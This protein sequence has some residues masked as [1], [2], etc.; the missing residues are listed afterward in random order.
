MNAPRD[1]A[2]QKLIGRN[3][4]EV[5][6]TGV[7]LS[8]A[9]L[10]EA[11]FAIAR[12]QDANLVHANLK[13]IN[14]GETQP[15]KLA[16]ISA[17]GRFIASIETDGK[18]RLWNAATGYELFFSSELPQNVA[19]VVF[20]PDSKLLASNGIN[21][22]IYLWDVETRSLLKTL[23]GH[24]TPIKSLAFSPDG[25][26]LASGGGYNNEIVIVWDVA[27]GNKQYT[28]IGHSKTV[29]YLA[30]SP[31]GQILASCQ[32]SYNQSS[33][34]LWDIAT[35][36]LLRKLEQFSH[37]IE[38][39]DFDVN[40]QSLLVLT[41]N[42]LKKIDLTGQ[43]L[44]FLP[45]HTDYV[46]SVAI[47]ADGKSLVSGSL[48]KT[49]RLWDLGTGEEIKVLTG[50]TS[51]VNSVAIS[52]DGQ[53]LVSGSLDKTIRLWDL[54]TGKEIKVFT[55][56]T[57]SV[58][59]VA[60]SADGQS[61][62]SGS[63]DKTI[64]LWDIGT[65]KEINVFTGH[66][67]LVYSV[68][69]SADGQS[70][71]SG[72]LDKTIRL[73]DIVTGKEI[74]VFTGH[75]DY[76]RSVAVSPDGQS[77][78][79]GSDD[80]TIRL[81]DIATGK[82][83]NVLTG[84]TDY[85][86]SVAI[87][88]D[89]QFLVSGS[90]DKT[91]RLWDIA[92]GK[93]IKVIEGR[94]NPNCFR[95]LPKEENIIIGSRN[96]E[97]EIWD[98]REI[99]KIQTDKLHKKFIN[100]LDYSA[101]TQTLISAGLDK[102]IGL[103]NLQT[104]NRR[105]IRQE[106]H[107]LRAN[108]FGV[109]G[110]R[111]SQKELLLRKGA[112]EIDPTELPKTQNREELRYW[113][114]TRRIQTLSSQIIKEQKRKN[115]TTI[116]IIAPGTFLPPPQSLRKEEL[117][118]YREL[119]WFRRFFSY[120]D[121]SYD[122]KNP[123]LKRIQR[124]FD[125]LYMRIIDDSRFWSEVEEFSP[126][127]LSEKQLWQT[128]KN[129]PDFNVISSLRE[130]YAAL[131]EL[132]NRR[133]FDIVIDFD[134]FSQLN[135]NM[136]SSNVIEESFLNTEDF[137]ESIYR[138]SKRLRY[139]EK[140][141][142][143]F[144]K[145][146]SSQKSPL[147]SKDRK[148]SD[149]RY[150]LED[151]F[152]RLRFDVENPNFILT[153]FFVEGFF[154]FDR[155]FRRNRG[156]DNNFYWVMDESIREQEDISATYL[157]YPVGNFSDFFQDLYTE[158]TISER[159]ESSKFANLTIGQLSYLS[160]NNDEQKRS[161]VAKEVISRMARGEK[162]NRN[163]QS[164][165]TK[166]I[167]SLKKDVS[168]SVRLNFLK[169]ILNNFELLPGNITDVIPDFA[170]DE[171]DSIRA[172]LA[173]WIITKYNKFGKTY[174]SILSDL[175][176]DESYFVRQRILDA[177]KTNLE[178]L[179]SDIRQ[180]ASQLIG[181]QVSVQIISGSGMLIDQESELI[182]EVTN[183]TDTNLEIADLEIL[184][185]A[186]YTVLSRN[187]LSLADLKPE[188]S[189]QATFK[190]KINDPKEITV[191]YKFNGELK[192][193]A[194]SIYAVKGNPYVYGSIVKEEVAFYGRKQELQEIVQGVIQTPIINTFLIGERRLGK[195]SLLY[196]LKKRLETP[197]IPVNV[198]IYKNSTTE[199]ILNNI[200]DEV[201][202]SLIKNK[203]I[204]D[205]L[206][207]RNFLK[208]NNFV[209]SFQEI[210]ERA[211]LKLPNIKIV[212]LLDEADYLLS[213]KSENTGLSSKINLLLEK[214]KGQQSVIEEMKNVLSSELNEIDETVQNILRSALQQLGDNLVAVVAGTSILSSYGAKYNSPFL[215]I[216]RRITL[217][218]LTEEET[219]ALITQPASCLGYTYSEEAINHIIN[220]SGGQPY[221]CQA[222]CYEAFEFATTNQRLS[223]EMNDIKKAEE[224][225]IEDLFDSYFSGFWDRADK[226]QRSFLKNLAEGKSTESIKIERSQI[227]ELINWNLI[228]REQ[229]SYVFCSELNKQWVLMA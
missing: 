111:E 9:D 175:A 15:F 199:E 219:R 181:S 20:S 25:K 45:G 41:N 228:R 109:K 81:W 113:L 149:M 174:Q 7:D 136:F 70:L 151:F 208:S 189:T 133:S 143:L 85:V 18:L 3:F 79:S 104:D 129:Q 173:I 190:L 62:V 212:W 126:E 145:L 99:K 167:E 61:L 29:N 17:D 60:I 135:Q 171:D 206:E 108:I 183:E 77:L 204:D 168:S 137:R 102:S 26:K 215:N 209:E 146:F 188:E 66:K 101:A 11:N 19:T 224:K 31:D 203:I 194:L 177:I 198:D 75:T 117:F 53:S 68:A 166:L 1:Y 140:G 169:N 39:L 141:Q 155:R 211:K 94:L 205:K 55:G 16:V 164:R 32:S 56:H 83:I 112:I 160:N 229:N 196:Q 14:L 6:L 150:L 115:Q 63:D 90:D 156:K 116:L 121:F 4:S 98:L 92:T 210:I 172:D 184:P 106:L 201:I 178:Q 139:V 50:H 84:H 119:K 222:L 78:V 131:I 67:S 21:S 27:T 48:D 114:R 58:N 37:S 107:C 221:C 214:F 93:E 23:E 72:S 49:I 148:F 82:E 207:N 22:S 191:N 64:R 176:E 52:A 57:S 192:S 40:G 130:N 97:F 71:V 124:E 138:I 2:Y 47:S 193:P 147:S 216:F 158:V 142:T 154:P 227:K 87:S 42:D 96:G 38:S 127:D 76:V 110:L 95:Q 122:E 218:M 225:V 186:E 44:S 187:P 103:L 12:L 51:S 69:I 220:L 162:Y 86:R 105:F 144:F 120:G 125:D 73:W 30:F 128:T 182:L 132:V 165:L 34:Y 123:N 28:L 185:S 33:I 91:I 46:R 159:T 24:T 118:R 89:G 8:Y 170:K 36:N 152:E 161:K 35:G 13:G 80:K 217:K 88:P 74:N 223:I 43:Y 213:I 5:N 10:Q 157:D 195:T 179:P 65:G 180:L 54:G 200:L 197:F 163:E 100:S 202:S 59:S 153:G 134:I 226:T